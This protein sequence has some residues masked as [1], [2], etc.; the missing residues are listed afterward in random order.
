M[1]GKDTMSKSMCAEKR[2]LKY[3]VYVGMVDLHRLQCTTPEDLSGEASE[4]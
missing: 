2:C 1:E 4:K 3:D